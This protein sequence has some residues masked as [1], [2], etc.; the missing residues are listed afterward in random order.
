[1]LS[2]F[3]KRVTILEQKNAIGFLVGFILIVCLFRMFI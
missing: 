3:R 1:M 2:I